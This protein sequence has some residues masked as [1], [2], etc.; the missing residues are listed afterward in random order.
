MS[1]TE[2]D[3]KI[4]LESLHIAQGEVAAERKRLEDQAK[5]L[6]FRKYDANQREKELDELKIEIEREM[7]HLEEVGIKEDKVDRDRMEIK[8]KSDCLLVE[9]QDLERKMKDYDSKL[10][11]V[12]EN[13]KSLAAAGAKL[14]VKERE[15]SRY[16]I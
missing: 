7:L 2:T 1:K 13:A 16:L 14:K 8:K 9:K 15:V 6:E 5:N 12:E 3:L 10:A 4:N 11:V